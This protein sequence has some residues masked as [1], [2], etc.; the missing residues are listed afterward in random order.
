MSVL[1]LSLLSWSHA[2]LILAASRGRCLLLIIFITGI[3]GLRNV[4]LVLSLRHSWV[5]LNYF[6]LIIRVVTCWSLLLLSMNTRRVGR[7][8]LMVLLVKYLSDI[9]TRLVIAKAWLTWVLTLSNNFFA[10]FFIRRST[11]LILLACALFK[12]LIVIL[13][14]MMTVWYYWLLERV[15]VRVVANVLLLLHHQSL[16]RMSRR[17]PL[18]VFDTKRICNI[19]SV[20]GFAREL[21]W[22][23]LGYTLSHES[24]LLVCES[25]SVELLLL[26]QNV[27][28]FLINRMIAVSRSSSLIEAVRLKHLL[29]RQMVIGVLICIL[30]SN[31]WRH[32][33]TKVAC[34]WTS[35]VA[36]VTR[37]Q[38][39]LSELSLPSSWTGVFAA[40]EVLFN[41]AGQIFTYHSCLVWF[42]RLVDLFLVWRS[43][44]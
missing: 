42:F 12:S 2:L 23:L 21:T 37:F 25:R 33:V 6:W 11:V 30:N 43:V 41:R 9:C 3:V 40:V 19:H 26:A 44:S 20:V 18:S 29:V 31:R 8:I 1:L 22:W 34:N 10:V 36:S 39:S 15:S 4:V 27:T 13:A 35:L 17:V 32:L 28:R 16:I 24:L 14:L 5:P 38:K 7:S